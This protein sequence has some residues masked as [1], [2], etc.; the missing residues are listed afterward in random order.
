MDYILY[1]WKGVVRAIWID[2]KD[3]F[4]PKKTRYLFG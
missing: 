3:L 4:I 2:I 1:G